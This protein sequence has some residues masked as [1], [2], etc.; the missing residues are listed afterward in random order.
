VGE[1]VAGAVIVEGRMEMKIW[2]H[3]TFNIQHS[4]FNQG[5]SWRWNG[6]REISND[7]A[8]R[9]YRSLRAGLRAWRNG[10][11]GLTGSTSYWMSDSSYRIFSLRPY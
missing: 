6:R 4:T 11:H 8:G 9:A 3:S 5:R 7:R 2:K 1:S 10:T